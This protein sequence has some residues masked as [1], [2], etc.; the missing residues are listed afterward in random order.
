MAKFEF[1]SYVIDLDNDQTAELVYSNHTAAAYGGHEN[2][3]SIFAREVRANGPVLLISAEDQKE[4][5]FNGNNERL[6]QEEINENL[7]AIDE[8]ISVHL[9]KELSPFEKYGGLKYERQSFLLAGIDGIPNHKNFATLN[10]TT[11]IKLV[12]LDKSSLEDAGNQFGTTKQSYNSIIGHEFRHLNHIQDMMKYPSGG[13]RE[14]INEEYAN[15]A[16]YSIKDD[17]NPIGEKGYTSKEAIADHDSTRAFNGIMGYIITR[18]DVLSSTERKRNNLQEYQ[19]DLA[20]EMGIDPKD[21]DY[22]AEEITYLKEEIKKYKADSSLAIKTTAKDTLHHATPLL[23]INP[24]TIKNS[25]TGE[26]NVA[27]VAERMITLGQ[28]ID[29]HIMPSVL[30]AALE[31]YKFNPKNTETVIKESGFSATFAGNRQMHPLQLGLANFLE[32]N[33]LTTDDTMRDDFLDLNGYARKPAD[34]IN[35]VIDKLI[36]EKPALAKEYFKNEGAE[37]A[38]QG[39][40]INTA[41]TMMPEIVN[42]IE[43]AYNSGAFQGNETNQHMFK[44]ALE[45]EKLAT[46]KEQSSPDATENH[47]PDQSQSN[48]PTYAH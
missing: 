5:I 27:A 33:D 47:L 7:T 18:L 23:D 30:T 2:I 43:K 14:L 26:F 28:A 34:L 16:I 32:K 17:I 12:R 9:G 1:Y 11:G 42:T 15:Q 44:L 3:Q 37:I 6:P 24:D 22:D 48:S 38:L 10:E 21:E 20:F 36:K 35:S 46:I 45:S 4:I 13:A 19:E 31:Q 40:N 41:S 25:I 39:I 8:A 29:Q